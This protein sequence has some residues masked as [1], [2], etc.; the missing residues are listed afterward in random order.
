MLAE[1]EPP[2]E[3][4]IGAVRRGGRPRVLMRLALHGRSLCAACCAGRAWVARCTHL[5][6]NLALACN[7]LRAPARGLHQERSAGARQE[8]SPR[9]PLPLPLPLQR[10]GCTEG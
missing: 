4:S 1:H 7:R 3:F 5:E 9:P 6:P 2:A 8:L 10:A